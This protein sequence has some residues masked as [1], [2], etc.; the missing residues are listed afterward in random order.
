MGNKAL[1]ISEQIALLKER[2]ML[3]GDLSKTEEVLLDV[4]YYRLGFYWFPFEKSYPCKEGRLHQFDE[5]TSF[6]NIVKLY[7][8][9]FNLR[10]LLMKFLNRIEINFR[11]FLTYSMSNEHHDSP[12]WFVDP[13]IVSAEYIQKF[14]KEVYNNKVKQNPILQRHHK[15]HINDKYAPA[16]KTIEFM[17]LGEVIHL[18][19]SI[20]SINSQ[21]VISKHFG[22]NNTKTFLSY[23][24]VI[25]IVRNHC[26]HGN[27]LYDIA[28][29]QSIRRGPAGI[30][31]PKNYQR[32]AGVIRV[33]YYMIGCVS[34]NRQA[35]FKNE[36]IDLFSK[37]DNVPEVSSIIKTA[38]GI[39]NI[40]EALV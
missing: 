8:F 19:Q 7:Y 35:D 38:T 31:H 10:N 40:D 14:E 2:G 9:D 3:I 37:Y 11:T 24:S 1:T 21:L 5:G 23:L 22:L 26:A 36:L 15:V 20:K 39:E 6:D 4:G 13:N 12:T 18:Y 32:L 16:W 27:I 28:L 17:T 33:I 25:R 34:R 30:V 29:F